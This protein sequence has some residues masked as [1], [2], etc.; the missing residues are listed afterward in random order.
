MPASL[1]GLWKLSYRPE[2]TLVNFWDQ[3]IKSFDDPN[4]AKRMTD[5]LRKMDFAS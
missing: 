5:D 2:R 4:L 3:L 1:E